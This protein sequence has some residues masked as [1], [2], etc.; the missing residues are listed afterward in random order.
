MMRATTKL[1]ALAAGLWM[2]LVVPA[3]A[4]ADPTP[5]DQLVHSTADAV[6]MVLRE[7]SGNDMKALTE[8]VDTKVVDH[9]DFGAMTRLAVGKHWRTADDAQRRA[10]VEEFRT[11]LVR[12]Y[13]VALQQ[14]VDY[15]IDY[16][17]LTLEPGAKQAVVQ[18]SVTKGGSKPIRMDYRMIARDSGWKVYD[19]LVDGVSLVVNYRSLFGSTVDRSGIDGL[20]RLL[21]DKN[22]AGT[23][24]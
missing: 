24:G 17:P 9:F 16:R 22:A 15:E 21:R 5:P 13:S 11:L 3:S 7:D 20:I 12:T 4:L 14:F 18:T 8:V 1:P 23:T 19:V 10:L 2:L 6:F